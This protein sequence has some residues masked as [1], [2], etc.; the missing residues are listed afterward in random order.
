MARGELALSAISAH[1]ALTGVCCSDHAQI[2]CW[3]ELAL[4]SKRLAG[5]APAGPPGILILARNG[6]LRRWWVHVSVREKRGAQL[7]FLQAVLSMAPQTADQAA[8]HLNLAW[9]LE[10]GG[11]V[12][13]SGWSLASQDALSDWDEIAS[14]TVNVQ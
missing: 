3:V 10:G 4:C 2:K 9:E 13:P 1:V 5:C 14:E 12:S 11:G 6:E 8:D 7:A